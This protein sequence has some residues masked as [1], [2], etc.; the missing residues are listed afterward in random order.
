MTYEKVGSISACQCL[1]GTGAGAQRE[2]L[3]GWTEESDW[4]EWEIA[5]DKPGT[6][7]V[8]VNYSSWMNSGK[9]VVEVAGKSFEHTVIAAKSPRKQSPLIAAFNTVTV[10]EVALDTG[11]YKVAVKAVEIA[12]KAKEYSLGLMMLREVILSVKQ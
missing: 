5:A 12:P 1:D 4:A 9:F 6:Y 2:N 10:G 7:E 8:K 3:K 11:A